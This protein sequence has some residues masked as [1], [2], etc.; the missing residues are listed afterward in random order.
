MT[1]RLRLAAL[2][3]LLALALALATPDAA[4]HPELLRANP[5]ADA[6]L[7]AP[8]SRLELWF[9]ERIDAGAGSPS[10]AALD[11][12]GNR[13]D[14]VAA[15]DPADPRHLIVDAD[16]IGLGM[17]TIVWS[18]RSLDDGHTLAGS[19]AFRVGGSDRA[20]GAATVAGERPAP[21]NVLTRWLTFLGIALAAGAAGLGALPGIA[22]TA[23]EA[24]RRWG[25]AAAAGAI[26]AL[27]ATVAEPLLQ[28]ALTPAAVTVQPTL[29]E[30]LAVQPVWWYARAALLLV[31]AALAGVALT[32]RD[33]LRLP[34][35]L[36]ALAATLGLSATGHAA[37]RQSWRAAAI[38]IDALHL[39]ALALWVGG[40]LL[41]ALAWNAI[42]RPVLAAFSRA[43]LPLAAIGV[44][45]GVANSAL[46][47]PRLASL[48]QSDYGRVILFKVAVLLP[49]LALATLH[50]AT[51]RA[52]V[53]DTL[54]H[55][56][57]PR[58]RMPLRAEGALL[59]VV[60]LAGS[61]LA[62]L[63]TPTVAT[64]PVLTVVDLGFFADTGQP[65]GD[66]LALRLVVDPAVPGVNTLRVA[67]TAADGSPLP[68]PAVAAVRVTLGALVAAVATTVE[69]T[70]DPAAAGW[71]EAR[72][73]Q[74]SVADWW[75]ATVTVRRAGLPD[76]SAGFALLLP[77]PNVHGHAAPP[78]LASD[79]AAE[80]AF[81]QA[82]ARYTGLH[83]LHYTQRLTGGTG[84]GVETRHQVNDGADGSAPAS[85]VSTDTATVLVI[86]TMRWL[87]TPDGRWQATDGNPMIPPSAWGEDYTEARGFRLGRTEIVDG[88]LCQVV[89]FFAP[90]I[91]GRA[92]A[93]YAWWIDVET[94]DL[95]R[96]AM[97][98]RMHYMIDD[99]TNLDGNI[100]ITPPDTAATPTP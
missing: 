86:G 25:L 57:P 32:L 79:P 54:A 36:L 24:R 2:V 64:T 88:H 53:A 40:V 52:R 85:A 69:L 17:V 21:W 51:L 37:G 99:F 73:M 16:G 14:L 67:V 10:V 98:S 8:P 41:L 27:L 58:L 76:A 4:A 9:S 92:A 60:M 63:A 20:P 82:L 91:T 45:T 6:L 11:E 61:S 7:A 89:V 15:I 66:R 47:L 31:A 97:V 28:L 50:R 49:I 12:L 95:R 55:L 56:A 1:T 5:A 19:F 77:D 29:G 38:A 71:W 96:Q 75:W 65:E 43:A 33:E 78:D 68:D 81:Q 23:V 70:P 59:L 44:L 18:V 83:R 84:I 74:L 34:V 26:A 62:L 35:G 42:D 30:T 48:W 13:I 3:P 90:E 93:W 80:A 87:Q 46:V 72:G 22:A 100:V 94:G 39:G